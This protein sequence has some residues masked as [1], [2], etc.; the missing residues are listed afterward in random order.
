LLKFKI[1]Q[2]KDNTK[3]SCETDLRLKSQSKLNTHNDECLVKISH[4]KT[5]GTRRSKSDW[6]WT[7]LVFR[8]QNVLVILPYNSFL[9]FVY[10]RVSLVWYKQHMKVLVWI[11]LEFFNAKWTQN[12]IVESRE[13]SQILIEDN[14]GLHNFSKNFSRNNF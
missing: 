5:Q 1:T 6:K 4:Q 10:V 9:W 8:K 12:E 2:L 11:C 14:I 13:K 3:I 7:K